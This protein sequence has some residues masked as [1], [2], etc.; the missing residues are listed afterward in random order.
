MSVRARAKISRIASACLC[1]LALGAWLGASWHASVHPIEDLAEDNARIR[2]C[3]TTAATGR[4]D[5]AETHDC[6]I[7]QTGMM[8]PLAQVPVAFLSAPP[9]VIQTLPAWSVVNLTRP[10]VIVLPDKTGPPSHS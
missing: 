8:S 3:Q 4:M 6:P 1:A 7:C 5:A 9:P 10:A 2:E